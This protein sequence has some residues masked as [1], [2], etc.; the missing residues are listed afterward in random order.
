LGREEEVPQGAKGRNPL[1]VE[2]TGEHERLIQRRL[3]RHYSI[4]NKPRAVYQVHIKNIKGTLT[5][6]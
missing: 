3:I 5:L 4:D 6:S 1:L 2:I